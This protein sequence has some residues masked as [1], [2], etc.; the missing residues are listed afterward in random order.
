MSSVEVRPVLSDDCGTAIS[1]ERGV[2]Q[3]CPLSPLLF[4]LCYD[5]LI[6]ALSRVEGAVVCAF[7][8]DLAVSAAKL[9]TIIKSM[10]HVHDFARFS[11][12][13]INA[14]KTHVLHS[15]PTTKADKRLLERGT[16]PEVGFCD[17]MT[18]LGVLMGIKI[19]TVDVFNFAYM[20]FMDR[21]NSFYDTLRN[22][23]L[24]HRIVIVNVF[25]NSLF[26]YLTKFYYIPYHEI[27][28]R[29]RERVRKVVISFNGGGFSYAHLITTG[30]AKLRLSAPLRDLWAL[31]VSSLATR[32]NLLGFDGSSDW[33]IP[34]YAVDKENWGT[35]LM[36]EHSVHAAQIVL[37]DYLPRRGDG[38]IDASSLTDCPVKNRRYVY[39]LLVSV[40][41]DYAFQR[42]QAPS[43]SVQAKLAKM[44]VPNPDESAQHIHTNSTL[45]RP[46]FHSTVW[47]TQHSIIMNSLNTDTR[48][49]R[50][51]IPIPL[52]ATPSSPTIPLPCHICD[53]GRDSSYH[54]YTECS[55]VIA[56]R[57]FFLS[58][59][60]LPWPTDVTPAHLSTL[61]YP[62]LRSYRKGK[63][64]AIASTSFNWAVWKESRGYLR[65]ACPRP[66]FHTR[67]SRLV[68]L[69][70]L[71][72]DD[73]MNLGSRAGSL[74]GSAGSRDHA[75]T[76]AVREYMVSLMSQ[77]P[78]TAA[79]VFTDGSALGNPGPSGA[80][81][82]VEAPR[83]VQPPPPPRTLGSPL[84]HG[85]NN[86]AEL[87]A[88]GMGIQAARVTFPPGTPICVLTDSSYAIGCVTQGWN[89]KTNAKLVEAVKV[90]VHADS[91]AP[92]PTLH[93]VPGHCGV[94]GNEHAD[95]V[96]VTAAKISRR[97]PSR[98]AS[99]LS[100]ALQDGSFGHLADVEPWT[101]PD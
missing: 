100:G 25:L 45:A 64:L 12:L 87:Y 18:Y 63:L 26:S 23:P 38:T 55:T 54:I 28:V 71:K 67:V 15:I 82:H 97:D 96:A 83:E 13:R 95:D 85:T 41:D 77:I 47:S 40:A 91:S 73:A 22:S 79:I 20:K 21:F 1:I 68:S 27:V 2:K 35:M 62:P 34:G 37:A 70:S 44:G 94:D 57:R 84:G 52:C 60:G 80:G 61:S 8:D 24:S 88:I 5:P 92:T 78:A 46:S 81:A 14:G 43:T 101:V 99:F 75:Q 7:A 39:E 76:L 32:Q 74:Y 6:E 50:A 66:R 58:S 10:V 49:R 19:T 51:N 29:V 48:L 31:N 30:K 72:L 17:S 53:S 69:A 33:K 16:W 42:D 36:E 3:G 86:M 4:A 9:D 11:G 59:L 65:V 98:G 93:W 90:V 89:A 56:A